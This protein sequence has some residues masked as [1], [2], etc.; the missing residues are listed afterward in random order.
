MSSECLPGPLTP[1]MM[2]PRLNIGGSSPRSSRRTTSQ[3]TVI[4]I[5]TGSGNPAR[6]TA[7]MNCRVDLYR[8]CARTSAGI[9]PTRSIA[10]ARG[11]HV[12]ANCS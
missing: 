9:R 5:A 11:Y 12:L 8:S 2:S 7:A 10:S 4:G 6:R 3:S 1:K